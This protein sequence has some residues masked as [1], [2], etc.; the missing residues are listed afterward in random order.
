MGTP[1]KKSVKQ[2]YSLSEAYDAVLLV[3]QMAPRPPTSAMLSLAK[4]LV[5]DLFTAMRETACENETL[6]L[7]CYN[8]QN[9]IHIINAHYGR[10]ENATC[11][12]NIGTANTQCLLT[13]TRDVVNDRLVTHVQFWSALH[14]M[15]NRGAF[16]NV[17]PIH[18]STFCS[19]WTGQSFWRSVWNVYPRKA[20]TSYITFDDWFYDVS[21]SS[22]TIG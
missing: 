12:H 7:S 1:C 8:E 17:G 19:R 9:V 6:T 11:H 22:F 14:E 16:H 2:N 15:L 13:Q 10:L 3:R 5:C 4:F 21:R 20:L 18:G